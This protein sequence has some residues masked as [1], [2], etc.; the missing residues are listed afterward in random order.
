MTSNCIAAPI[1]ENAQ[2]NNYYFTNKW[3]RSHSECRIVGRSNTYGIGC[4]LVSFWQKGEIT[5]VPCTGA[6][7]SQR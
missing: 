5:G 7:E 4:D 2:N 1:I 6:D 3:L